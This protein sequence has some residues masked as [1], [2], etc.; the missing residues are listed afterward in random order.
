[1]IFDIQE[2]KEMKVYNKTE[3]DSLVVNSRKKRRE[4]CKI[5]VGN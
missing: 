5:R 2:I 1:M 4:K 3:T